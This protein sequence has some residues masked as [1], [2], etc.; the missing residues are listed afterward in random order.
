M[1]GLKPAVR[2][3]TPLDLAYQIDTEHENPGHQTRALAKWARQ[4]S[5]LRASRM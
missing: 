1:S 4:D 2:S 5:N 3:T